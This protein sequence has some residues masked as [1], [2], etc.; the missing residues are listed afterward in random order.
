[1]NPASNNNDFL[2][3][4]YTAIVTP[5]T[6]DGQS[7]DFHRLEENIRDQAEGGVTGVVPCGTTGESPTLR[8]HEQCEVIERAIEVGKP[9]GLRIVAGAGSNSTE[10][11][12]EMH[13]FAHKAGAD[14]ALQVNPYY[15]RP[16]QEGLYRHFM[17]IADSCDLP[18]MLYNIP[19]RTGVLVGADTMERL[20]KHPNIRAVKDA[21]GSLEMVGE[22]TART[23]LSVLSGDDPLT[24]PMAVVGAVGVVSVVSNLVPA[25]VAALCDEFLTG[26]WGAARAIHEQ[27][28]PL[29]RGLLSLDTN[30]VPL[31]TAMKVLGRDTG[32]LRQKLI[33]L[34]LTT[35][36]AQRY[37]GQL[38]SSD[39]IVFHLSD[40]E[41]WVQYPEVDNGINFHGHI[42]SR[43]DILR[44]NVHSDDPQIQP[45]HLFNQ[46]NDVNNP[47]A[48]RRDHA[49]QPKDHAPLVLVDDLDTADE[50]D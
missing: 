38:R 29:A 12:I 5:F 15:N 37:L 21:T 39:Q 1:M 44:G 28:L 43:D 7:V 9:L 2:R 48:A 32:A 8:Q 6:A 47:G 24:L 10:K 17:A 33:E 49:P 40:G 19:G 11:A 34:S 36:A 16:S 23:N 26:H 20:A 4:A 30:P 27:L 42:V 41:V 35:Y 3:G 22:V 50:Q 13:R 46:R 25:K 45:E 31:K 14:A 18:I